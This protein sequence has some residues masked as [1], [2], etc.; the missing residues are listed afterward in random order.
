[1]LMMWGATRSVTTAPGRGRRKMSRGVVKDLGVRDQEIPERGRSAA[2]ALWQ[3][4][5]AFPQVRFTAA[6]TAR[7]DLPPATVSRGCP[8]RPWRSCQAGRIVWRQTSPP[9]GSARAGQ[10]GITRSGG[11]SA[12]PSS[13]ARRRDRRES[14]AAS[15]TAGVTV[16]EYAGARLAT[17]VTTELNLART[18]TC[19]PRLL[20][21]LMEVPL[22]YAHGEWAVIDHRYRGV[23][24]RK[25]A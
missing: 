5:I 20:V 1:M 9:R 10:P 7:G 12:S 24:E 18:L 4:S 25:G 22:S 21:S 15:R 3:P 23:G 16:T 6:A 13:R 14:S 11:S 2:L 8:W 17:A 19:S